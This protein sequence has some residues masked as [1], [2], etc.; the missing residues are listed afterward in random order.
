M[1]LDEGTELSGSCLWPQ[2][3]IRALGFGH[4]VCTFVVQSIDI[5]KECRCD[6]K[7]RRYHQRLGMKIVR[8]YN[9]S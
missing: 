7:I 3:G 2:R 8:T 6:M 1:R 9:V 5:P 4:T